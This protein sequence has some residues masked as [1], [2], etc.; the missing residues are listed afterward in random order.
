MQFM[1]VARAWQLGIAAGILFG[2][3]SNA[4]ELFV[5]LPIRYYLK[6]ALLIISG[7]LMLSG[8]KQ[9]RAA[10]T[11]PLA[12]RPLPDEGPLPS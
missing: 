12:D 7:L 5:P 1:Q 10:Q 2:F 3:G 6:P 8:Y 11:E 9:V 4:I